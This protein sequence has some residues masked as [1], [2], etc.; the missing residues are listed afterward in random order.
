MSPMVKILVSGAVGAYA[1]HY[2]Q[3]FALAKVWTPK[4]ESEKAFAVALCAGV[5]TLAAHWAIEKV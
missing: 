5:A 2:V 3:D 4:T 1:G